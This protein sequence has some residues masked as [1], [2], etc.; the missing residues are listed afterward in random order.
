MHSAGSILADDEPP[1]YELI[2]G[3][4]PRPIII[5]CDH[6]ANRVPRSLDMLGLADHHLHDHIG[7]D[8]GAA[9]VARRL[10]Q[11]FD[12]DAVLAVYSRLVVDLN[13]SLHD[14]GAFAA[15]SDGILVPGN[16]GLSI[17]AKA[18]RARELYHPYHRTIRKLIDAGTSAEHSPIFIGIHSFT[19]RASGI[20]R[21]WHIGVLWDKDP[22]LPLPLMRGLRTAS[23]I[24]VADNEPYSGRHPAD[25][26]IDH[27][28]E[29]LGLAHA[30]IEIRQDLIRDEIGQERWAARLA[31]AL[32]PVLEHEAFY[33]RLETMG[34]GAV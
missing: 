34:K 28:A 33:T 17:E 19:P 32:R 1:A 31:D 7:W 30:G 22:R 29:L 8:I 5:V 24:V 4:G 27:H 2:E 20:E 16:V 21:P 3:S 26:T 12:A 10:A 23:D 14:A 15:I 11:W 9:G 13:R 25:F 18:A 6:A